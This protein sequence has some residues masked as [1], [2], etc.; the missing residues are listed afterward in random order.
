MVNQLG[1]H[2]P[3]ESLVTRCDEVGNIV[4]VPRGILVNPN[5]KYTYIRHHSMKSAE[6][7][8]RKLIRG[9]N[10]GLKYDYT[11]RIQSFFRSNK[12]TKEKLAVFEKVLNMTFP[13]FHQK[14][15]E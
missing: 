1:T 7:Y 11:S 6:E 9:R 4:N 5:Y 13:I 15:Y 10:N 3:N 2:Q 14:E 12:F 8:S